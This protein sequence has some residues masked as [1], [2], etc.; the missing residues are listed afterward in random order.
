MKLFQSSVKSALRPFL[1]C[2]TVELHCIILMDASNIVQDCS[3][4]I[5]T[6]ALTGINE[7][8]M[9]LIELYLSYNTSIKKN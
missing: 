8:L 9:N 2:D 6:K 1:V 5:G 4:E 7:V 3:P